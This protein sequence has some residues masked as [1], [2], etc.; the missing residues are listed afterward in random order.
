MTKKSIHV[1][2]L[3]I[4]TERSQNDHFKMN[5]TSKVLLYS[6]VHAKTCY[7]FP[8]SGPISKIHLPLDFYL[9]EGSND[10]F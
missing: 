9:C 10:A 8:I 7:N 6:L 4:Y 5:I 2:R 1:G 3:D